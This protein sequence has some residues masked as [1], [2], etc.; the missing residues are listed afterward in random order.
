MKDRRRHVSPALPQLLEMRR[1]YF[2]SQKKT[3]T[4][5]FHLRERAKFFVLP[6]HFFPS[7]VPYRSCVSCVA[8]FCCV[9]TCW[10]R[11][12][13][14]NKSKSTEHHVIMFQQLSTNFQGLDNSKSNDQIIIKNIFLTKK[15]PLSNYFF[16]LIFALILNRP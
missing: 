8:V 16:I 5:V 1:N 13:H 6:F 4:K 3:N 12:G 2:R 7:L 15:I 10:F 14:V 11:A 9:P